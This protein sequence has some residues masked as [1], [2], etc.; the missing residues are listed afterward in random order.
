VPGSILQIEKENFHWKGGKRGPQRQL[1]V[2]SLSAKRYSFF[3]FNRSG[4]PVVIGFK[5][6]G[7]GLYLNP[8]D[9][10]SKSKAWIGEMWLYLIRTD[11]L[12]LDTKPPDWFYSLAMRR[13]A[14][15]TW[16]IQRRFE[17][18]YKRRKGRVVTKPHK[19]VRP[20]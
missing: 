4:N 18:R 15:S 13:F 1:W 5:E 19:R 6:H 3:V 2:Y 9:P 7:L 20:G 12:G 10:E 14:S 16:E 8:G 11:G 17:T